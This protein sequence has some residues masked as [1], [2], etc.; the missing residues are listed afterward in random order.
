MFL[1][2]K[3]DNNRKDKYHIVKASID[4]DKKNIWL[5]V[6]LNKPIYTHYL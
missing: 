3:V 6:D 1:I 2:K 4:E 5:M